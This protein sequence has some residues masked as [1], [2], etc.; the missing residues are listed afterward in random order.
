MPDPQAGTAVAGSP[1]TAAASLGTSCSTTIGRLSRAVEAD[2]PAQLAERLDVDVAALRGHRQPGVDRA[3]GDLLRLGQPDQGAE[4]AEHLDLLGADLGVVGPDD[5]GR[6]REAHVGEELRPDLGRAADGE[7]ALV[8]LGDDRRR[9]LERRVGGTG[10]VD[11]ALDLGHDRVGLRR[12]P[13]R[14]ADVALRVLPR[15][16]R[17]LALAGLLGIVGAISEARS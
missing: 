2:R 3:D 5:L 1:S 7:L 16:A 14:G 17:V 15:C 8:H 4:V 12:A 9:P 13:E 6:H 10:L 11:Q